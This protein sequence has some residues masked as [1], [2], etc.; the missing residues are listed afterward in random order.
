MKTIIA[1]TDFSSS[2]VNAVNYAADLAIAIDAKLVLM[3][4]VK[5]PIT[6]SEVPMPGPIFEDMISFENQELQKLGSALE[7]RTGGKINISTELLIGT[8]E[9]QI[10]EMSKHQKPFAIAMGFTEGNPVERFFFGSKTLSA[11]KHLTFPVL[12]IPENAVFKGIHKIGLACDLEIDD[13]SFPFEALKKVLSAFN[14]SLDI[15]RVSKKDRY[16]SPGDLAGSVSFQHQLSRFNP[17]FHFLHYDKI[18]E[19]INEFIKRHH[20]ELLIITSRHHGL[21]ELFNEKHAK[22]I[23]LHQNVPVLAIHE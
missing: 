1:A 15:I 18:E 13:D 3:H 16:A 2:S 6:L 21:F 9:H 17:V 8:V 19:G 11:A 5:A 20:L 4:V 22:K 12:A 23:I 14:A 10:S 7:E